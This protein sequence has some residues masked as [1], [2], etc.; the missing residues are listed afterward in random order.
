MGAQRSDVVLTWQTRRFDRTSGMFMRR[1]F[2]GYWMKSRNREIAEFRNREIAE[3]RK[4]GNAQSRNAESRNRGIANS[5]ICGIAKLRNREIA[6]NSRTRETAKSR[7]RELEIG[8][9][10]M[11]RQLDSEILIW[12][13]KS[14]SYSEFANCKSEQRKYTYDR[15]I[16]AGGIRRGTIRRNHCTR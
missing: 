7:N 14:R 11:P 13:R 10:N 16:C 1:R 3:S 4:R 15:A 8:I 12:I 9:G 2:C 6:E 5:R